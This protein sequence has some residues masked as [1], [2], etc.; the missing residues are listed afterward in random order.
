MIS[1]QTGM[2]VL[3]GFFIASLVW[4]LLA[5]AFWSRA[6]RL[7]TQRL[8]RSMPVSEAE[9][10]A[11]RDRLRAEQA[12]KVHKL[13][14]RLDQAKLDR[15]R[16]LID[17]NRR[18]ASISAL[19]TD[20][21]TI[22]ADL[23][24]NQN[25]R[26]VLEQTVADRLPKVE[27]RLAEAKRLLFNRDREISDLT[28]SAKRHKLALEEASSINAQKAAQIDRLSSALTT[29][30]ARTR[31]TGGEPGA[32]GEV[33]LRVEA[34]SLR[35]KAREQA[36]LI[37]RLQRRLGQ[38]YV[39]PGP[40]AML[41]APASGDSDIDQARENLSEAETALKAVRS[42]PPAPSVA[43]AERARAGTRDQDAQSA[44]GRSGGRDCEAEGSAGRFRADRLE[45]RPE[46]QQACAQGTRRFRRGADRTPG[47]DHQQAQGRVGRSQRAPRPAS[48]A[49]HGRNAPDWWWNGSGLG[50]G[51]P[52]GRGHGAA[53]ARRARRPGAAGTRDRK[54][55]AA[56]SLRQARSRRRTA[57][58]GQPATAMLQNST[59][60]RPLKKRQLWHRLLHPRPQRCP[61]QQRYRR[62]GA[63][64]ACSTGSPA[65]PRA[66]F[67][68]ER[69]QAHRG[70]RRLDAAREVLRCRMRNCRRI[71]AMRRAPRRM[72]WG[73]HLNDAGV[74]VAVRLD[75]SDD[76]APQDAPISL[77]E[78]I[79]GEANA[80]APD[81][82]VAACATPRRTSLRPMIF[83]RCS[84]CAPPIPRPR[85]PRQTRR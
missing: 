44:H 28:Q 74:L 68:R 72:R 12:I 60:A 55:Q 9:I 69:E 56:P 15:A 26:R 13:E 64:R 7:T 76:A 51:A 65:W 49:L 85:C 35:T 14:T 54:A 8:K 62:R 67:R 36:A 52:H 34:E 82:P 19:E 48:R 33:A 45:R 20:I 43:D 79:E 27:A 70:G 25:A 77:P 29:R 18:D 2:L 11:D 50:T 75:A 53:Q 5:S 23:E 81:V 66:E 78:V 22:R 46:E 3:L 30:G 71:L 31:R 37:D 17:I 40:M 63:S 58:K 59:P 10:K 21:V 83:S 84:T 47:G 6:V 80:S 39:V 73:T 1:I 4:L 41:P 24:E 57:P 61:K 42:P 38:G 16:Q 32:E